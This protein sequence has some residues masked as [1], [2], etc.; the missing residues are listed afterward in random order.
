MSSK[1]S[2]SGWQFGHLHCGPKLAAI[3]ESKIIIFELNYLTVL[4]RPRCLVANI[5]GHLDFDE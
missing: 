2:L 4:P 1:V 3:N 5:T